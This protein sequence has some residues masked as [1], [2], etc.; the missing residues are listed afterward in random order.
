[1]A[2][3]IH[4]LHVENF[5]AF[6]GAFDLPV[7]G[8]NILLYGENGSG[9]SSIY[10]SFYTFYQACLKSVDQA[11]KYFLF[12]N[13]ENL[14]NRY[15]GDTDYS[16]MKLSFKN[17]GAM[18]QFED[19]SNTV[20]VSDSLHPDFMKL[21]MASSDFMNYKFLA[22]IFD[23]SNSQENDIFNVLAKEVFPFLYFRDPLVLDGNAVSGRIDA[24]YWWKYLSKP[25]DHVPTRNNSPSGA[26]VI[27][28]AKYTQ[29]QDNLKKF[30]DNLRRE[31]SLIFND[32]NNKLRSLFKESISIYFEYIDASF[33]DR[34]GTSKSHDGKLHRP[35]IILKAKMTGSSASNNSIITHPR[36]FFNEA[37]LTCMALALRLAFHD[38]RNISGSDFAP[39]IFIDDLLIS[40]DMGC[41]KF[42][43]PILLKYAETKQMFIF[44]HDRAFFS[45]CWSEIQKIEKCQDWKRLE[46]YAEDDHGIIKPILINGKSPIEIAKQ[47]YQSLDLS[48]CANIIRS[49][50]EKELKRILP[51][52]YVLKKQTSDDDPIQFNNLNALIGQLGN[53]RKRFFDKDLNNFPN[54]AP[55][56][57]NDRK[58][59]MNPYSHDDIETPLYRSELKQAIES[60]EKLTKIKKI[61]LISDAEIGNREFKMTINGSS[62]TVTATFCFV[63]RF[64]RV[65]YDGVRYYSASMICVKN[66]SNSGINISNPNY[67]VKKLYK[68]LYESLNLT[69][70]TRPVF[71]DCIQSVTD[72]KIISYF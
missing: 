2:W 5:K 34:I 31:L 46:L 59:I 41:R 8:K 15:S 35:K 50:C 29:Y 62:G 37:R 65:T 12:D 64:E 54:I 71:E 30:N 56:L 6:K 69:V 48:G 19:S 44:T 51:M 57:S 3:K 43:I 11:Q 47:K 42:I 17:G 63:E 7:E 24:D 21:S 68:D 61:Q 58:L 32:A 14:R 28:S 22:S 25:Q 49:A 33:N 53:F 27:S 20:S 72:G 52:N 66:I 10:W 67:N 23:F 70:A 38:A 45:L 40:L 1:M 18:L 9:K 60:V 4:N 26:Y 39:A 13:A 36:S 55:D 16:G